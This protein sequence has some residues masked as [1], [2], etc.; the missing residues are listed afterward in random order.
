MKR[1]FYDAEL[2][3]GFTFIPTIRNRHGKSSH[4]LPPRRCPDL[5]A[6]VVANVASWRLSVCVCSDPTH[7]RLPED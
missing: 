5:G 3:Q 6:F 4:W 1:R 7:P 2:G